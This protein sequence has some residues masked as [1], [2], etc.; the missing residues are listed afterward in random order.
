MSRSRL[1]SDVLVETASHNMS[2]S[3]LVNAAFSISS[4]DNSDDDED[5]MDVD[6]DKD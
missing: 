4:S 2:V 5:E 6:E 1:A 3:S